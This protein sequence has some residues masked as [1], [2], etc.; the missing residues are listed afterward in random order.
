[1]MPLYAYSRISTSLAWTSGYLPVNSGF[2]ALAGLLVHRS[3]ANPMLLGVAIGVLVE[4]V[5][6]RLAHA[7]GEPTRAAPVL[8]AAPIEEVIEPYL[9]QLGMVARTARGRCLNDAGWRHLGLA[10][11][12]GTQ[13]GLF[14]PG[15]G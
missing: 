1:M 12:A 10:P 6:S 9:I 15:E 7:P 2:Q 3:F 13:S 14:A 8:Y 4:Q 11:P 5:R